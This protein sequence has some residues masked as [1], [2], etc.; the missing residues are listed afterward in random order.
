LQFET[1]CAD[2]ASAL[3]SGTWGFVLFDVR[4]PTLFALGHMPGAVL[5]HGKIERARL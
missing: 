1:D 5:A 2:V 4:G 3:V